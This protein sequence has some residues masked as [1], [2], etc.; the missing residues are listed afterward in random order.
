VLQPTLEGGYSWLLGAGSW[1][2]DLT[3]GLGAEINLQED[4][5]LPAGSTQR[6]D[7]GEGAIFLLG[8]SFLYNG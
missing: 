8:L 3:A 4:G 5:N 6:E 1:S 2:L 7:V